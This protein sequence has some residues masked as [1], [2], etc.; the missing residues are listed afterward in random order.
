MNSDDIKKKRDQL[1]DYTVDEIY[2]TGVDDVVITV[3][4]RKSTKKYECHLISR[5]PIRAQF[6]SSILKNI[7]NEYNNMADKDGMIQLEHDSTD[8]V[9]EKADK[10]ETS[11]EGKEEFVDLFK[12]IKARNK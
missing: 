11:S 4:W 8:R 1:V 6:I 5:L 2:E 3:I 7:T 10:K 12:W 9:L